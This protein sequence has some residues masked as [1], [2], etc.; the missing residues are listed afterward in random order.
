[1]WFPTEHGSAGGRKNQSMYMKIL[2][3][4]DAQHTSAFWELYLYELF[5]SLGFTLEPHT[6]IEGSA[7]HPDFLVK[8][9]EAPSFY[10]EGIVAG[11]PSSK[12]RCGSSIGRGV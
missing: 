5:S 10:L 9:G 4:L 8:E 2:G 1:M 3:F 7:N 12:C 11:L 6:N